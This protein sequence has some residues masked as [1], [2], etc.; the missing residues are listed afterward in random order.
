M[1]DT[2]L[3]DAGLVAAALRGGIS[4]EADERRRAALKAVLKGIPE[5]LRK[6]LFDELC[7]ELDEEERRQSLQQA[8]SRLSTEEMAHLLRTLT[9]SVLPGAAS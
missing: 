8:F 5:G 9:S 3:A 7:G 2:G 6:K 1:N 4:L